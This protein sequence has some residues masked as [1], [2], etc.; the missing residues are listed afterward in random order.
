M[1]GLLKPRKVR[2]FKCKLCET[3][4][5]S[6]KDL[7]THH[8]KEH[9]KVICVDCNQE[10]NM[11]SSLER[12]AYNHQADLKHK[13]KK[14]G[15]L[16][17]FL[18]QLDSHKI[19]HKKIAT[20]KCNKSILKGKV[21]GKWFKCAGE[22]KKHLLTHSKVVWKCQNCEYSTYDERNLKQHLWKH[23]GAKPFKCTNCEKSFA[24]WTQR[25]RH[26]CSKA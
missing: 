15:K 17:A 2:N 20:F 7:N 12:H 13:C 21:C 23:T 8:R 25:H 16:F 1:H 11:P 10:F 24:Y 18:S 9:D 4:T 19:V 3:I 26:K 22:L 6:R 5:T 14:C